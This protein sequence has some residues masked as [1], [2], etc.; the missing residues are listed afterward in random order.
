MPFIVLLLAAI[1]IG[2]LVWA[3]SDIK[4]P[5]R[6]VL[7]GSKGKWLL[8][9]IFGNLIGPTAYLLVGRSFRPPAPQDQLPGR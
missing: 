5:E 8:I 7:G 2:L 3:I 1:Q 4:K 6:E 9:V